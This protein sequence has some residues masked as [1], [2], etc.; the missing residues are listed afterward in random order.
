MSISIETMTKHTDV[1][2]QSHGFLIEP[3]E[4]Q[5][6]RLMRKLDENIVSNIYELQTTS[7]GDKSTSSA[8][9]SDQ[10]GQLA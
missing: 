1:L 3:L 10:L 2:L 5:E 4:R 6:L 9:S 7:A 8:R